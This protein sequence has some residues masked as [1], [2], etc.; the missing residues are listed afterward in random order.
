M[1]NPGQAAVANQTIPLGNLGSDLSKVIATAQQQVNPAQQQQQPPAYNSLAQMYAPSQAYQNVY[2]PPPAQ[3][4]SK[5]TAAQ[6]SA[7]QEPDADSLAGVDDYKRFYWFNLGEAKISSTHLLN[8][9]KLLPPTWNDQ[10]RR[11][12]NQAFFV[13]SKQ[14]KPKKLKPEISLNSI[15]IQG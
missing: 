15:K 9:N 12:L 10:W 13:A 11:V 1:Y 2:S 3:M 5:N 14:L 4:D 7:K 8:V 6:E